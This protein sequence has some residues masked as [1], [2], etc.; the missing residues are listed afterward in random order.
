MAPG[1]DLH[2]DSGS[3]LVTMGCAAVLGKELTVPQVSWAGATG[4]AKN[5]CTCLKHYINVTERKH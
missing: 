3:S 4:I 2:E 1:K 5:L